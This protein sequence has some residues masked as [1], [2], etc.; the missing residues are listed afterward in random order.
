MVLREPDRQSAKTVTKLAT[1]YELSHGISALPMRETSG[2][3]RYL[4]VRALISYHQWSV[5]ADRTEASVL[6][7]AQTDRLGQ[8]VKA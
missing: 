2:F 4:P 3:A 1:E 8:A 7:D 6:L 5:K